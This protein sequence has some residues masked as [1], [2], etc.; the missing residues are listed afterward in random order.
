MKRRFLKIISAVMAFTLIIGASCAYCFST[1]AMESVS[2]SYDYLCDYIDKNSQSVLDVFNGLWTTKKTSV[3]SS[4]NTV[5]AVIMKSTEDDSIIFFTGYLNLTSE[6][7]TGCAMRVTKNDSKYAVYIADERSSDSYTG[8]ASVDPASYKDSLSFTIKKNDTTVTNAER[9]V[10]FNK[11]FKDSL[12][13]WEDLL[14]DKAHISLANF[15]FSKLGYTAI[16]INAKLNGLVWINSGLYYYKNGKVD[17][18]FKGLAKYDGKW[19]Y[20]SNG[21]VDESY[22]GIADNAYGSWYVKKGTIDFSKNGVVSSGLNYYL[23]KNGK[24]DDSFTGLYKYNGTWYYFTK[25]KLDAKYVG[26]AKNDYGWWYVKN[27]TIDFSYTGMAKNDYG[28]WYITNGKLDTKYT[29][30]A[31]NDYGWWY[32]TNGKLDRTFT[33]LA[34]NQYGWWYLSKGTIDYKF[35]GLA[36]NQYGWWYVRNGKIDTT[37]NGKASNRYGTWN[38]RNGKVVS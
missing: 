16:D 13:I 28:W 26:M 37:Y 35:V 22:V 19:Y 25:G 8:E 23:I 5:Y 32:M 4:Y 7:A 27:G 20:I 15:G 36:K 29:G 17:K 3:D 31:K 14:K 12:S 24:V 30:M 34:K 2:G 21:T 18:S 1:A 38:V 10:L 6:V 33:G 9:S 11:L